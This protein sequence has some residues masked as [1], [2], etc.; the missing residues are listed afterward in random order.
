M[1]FHGQ[2]FHAFVVRPSPAPSKFVERSPSPPP[3]ATS[4]SFPWGMVR[5]RADVA[6]DHVARGRR[7]FLSRSTV[8]LTRRSSGADSFLGSGRPTKLRAPLD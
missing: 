8:S 1:G 6:S 4:R 2:A 5:A 7:P 3:V